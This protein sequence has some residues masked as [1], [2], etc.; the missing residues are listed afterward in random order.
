M[1]TRTRMLVVSLVAVLIVGVMGICLA[2]GLAATQFTATA[3]ATPTPTA[4]FTATPTAT[5]TATPRPTPRP[6]IASSPTD[7]SAPA[8]APGPDAIYLGTGCPEIIPEINLLGD[9]HPVVSDVAERWYPRGWRV[10]R[11]TQFECVE[12]VLVMPPDES[13]QVVLAYV[14]EDGEW[15]YYGEFCEAGCE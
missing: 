8:P 11:A 10:R 14:W 2:G 12:L 3:T 1:N 6:T 9:K 5:F 7:D 15:R 13:Q 4:T